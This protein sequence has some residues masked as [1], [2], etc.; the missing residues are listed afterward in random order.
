MADQ[1]RQGPVH[2]MEREEPVFPLGGETIVHDR[3]RN[4]L[5]MRIRGVVLLPIGAEVELTNPNV[6]ATVV[7]V[8]LLAGTSTRPV[9]VC[10]DVEVPTAYWGY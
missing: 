9:H 4:R 6:N 5:V 7:G 10:L 3:A 2:P 1:N 8:R